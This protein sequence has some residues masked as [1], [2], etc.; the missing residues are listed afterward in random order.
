MKLKPKRRK[1]RRDKTVGLVKFK[2]TTGGYHHQE[3]YRT[4]GL[5]FFKSA[6]GMLFHR[7]NSVCDYLRDGKITHSAV[8]YLCGNTGFIRSGHDFT[9]D[10]SATGGM[11]CSFCEFK[12]AQK[13]MPSADQLVGHHVHVGRLR[14]EQVCCC[15]H[16]SN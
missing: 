5:P 11:V 14:V 15:E 13:K 6:A 4:R 1:R 7:V 9:A 10:P 3:R 8:G 2:E 12:A 16:H